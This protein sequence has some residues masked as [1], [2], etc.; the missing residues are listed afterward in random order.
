MEL[1][2]IKDDSGVDQ[3]AKEYAPEAGF[4]PEEITIARSAQEARDLIQECLGQDPKRLPPGIALVD[5]HL[6]PGINHLEDGIE[7]IAELKKQFPDCAIICFTTRGDMG[8]K[9]GARAIQNGAKD[10][11]DCSWAYVNWVSLTTSKLYLWRGA[12][13]T[14]AIQHGT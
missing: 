4:K 5:P 1:W 8:N 13:E 9:I 10:Y 3:I 14:A 7:V 2:L 12:Q 6:T 11:I